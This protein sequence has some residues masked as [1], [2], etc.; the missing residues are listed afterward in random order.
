MSDHADHVLLEYMPAHL[1]ASHEAAGNWG[2]YPDNGAV[3]IV[4]RR[5]DADA[6]VKG[7]IYG[8][9]RVVRDVPEPEAQRLGVCDEISY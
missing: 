6:E 8:Y 4:M 2:R 9:A 1:A 5:D 7:D 3:R